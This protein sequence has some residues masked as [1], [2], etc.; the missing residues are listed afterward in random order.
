M[1]RV[2]S[3][4]SLSLEAVKHGHTIS[5]VGV[6]PCT[7]RLYF[8]GWGG[9]VDVRCTGWGGGWGGGGHVD[10]PVT[11]HTGLD[12][13]LCYAGDVARGGGGHVDVRCTGW[14]GLG[15]GGHVDVPVT[16]HTGLDATLCYAGDVARGGGGWGGGAMKTK[17]LGCSQ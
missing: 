15:W 13:T 7:G 4:C 5:A 1:R 11:L 6:E 2:L 3:S 9:H 12:A 16:L 10:V 8:S 14:G 17:P